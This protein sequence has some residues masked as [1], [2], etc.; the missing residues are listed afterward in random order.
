MGAGATRGALQKNSVPP[1]LDA[2]FFEIAG[3]ING[4]GTLRLAR[5]V[6]NDVRSLYRKFLG[7]GLENYYRDIETR[8]KIGSITRSA[9]RPKEWQ[10][11]QGDLE[12]L[13]RRIIV[14]TTC[15]SKEGRLEPVRSRAHARILKMLKKHDT[16]LTF[17]YDVLIEHSFGKDSLW[18]PRDGYGT[19]VHGIRN[20]WCQRWFKQRDIGDDTRTEIK[21]LKLHGSVNWTLKNGQIRLKDR[22][23]VVRTRE[24]RTVF[25]KVSILP[26]GLN[27][28][29]DVNPYRRL[30]KLA[31][32]RLERCKTLIIVGYSLPEADMLARALFA[33]VVRLR[34]V[35]DQ[36]PRQLHLADPSASVKQRFVELFTPAL[37]AQSRIF[38]YR[39]INEFSR[40]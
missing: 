2:D 38:R 20:E 17:N 31:R 37:D 25:E 4:H 23:F 33:E 29:I 21:L 16:I 18:T 7:V 1:P 8:A 32:L 34:V 36:Y 3:Q 5:L 27:K 35:R 10:R 9:N 13:I 19:T 30:W 12:E 15:K 22:P 6:L 39:D 26:P 11:Y 28:R 40:A 14:H 24:H